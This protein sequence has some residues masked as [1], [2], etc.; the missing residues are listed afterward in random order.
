MNTIEEKKAD[1]IIDED[2]LCTFLCK[3]A[4]AE[5]LSML[6]EILKCTKEE[7]RIDFAFKIVRKIYKYY[8]TPLGY[9]LKNP[10]VDNMCDRV[11]KKLKLSKLKGV[12]WQKLHSLGIN[13]FEK[14][15]KSM[16][17]EDKEKLLK[18]MWEKL[19]DEDK[20][21]LKNEFHLA[22]VSSFIHSSELLAAHVLGVHLARETALYTAAAIVRINLGAE[23]ALFTSR[24]LTRT[25]TVFLGPVGWVLLVVSVNDL[26]GTNFKRIVP[27]L[28]AVN[29]VNMRIH[30]ARGKEFLEYLKKN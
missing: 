26:M 8:Q 13:V 19:S 25:A 22:N 7:S 14:F 24:I 15:L 3:H 17:V 2:E 12:G 27:A 28:L 30:E 11:A 21:K 16:S 9:I 4:N 18:E 6:G 29:I 20:V 5:E 10:T 23:V 1:I